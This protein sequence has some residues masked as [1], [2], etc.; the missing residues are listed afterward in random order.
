L[1]ESNEL[2]LLEEGTNPENVPVSRSATPSS[3]VKDA[4][5]STGTNNSGE[6][7]TREQRIAAAL[8]RTAEYVVENIHA[9]DQRLSLS[10]TTLS[11]IA[12]VQEMDERNQFSATVANNV[13]SFDEKYQVSERAQHA[14]NTTVTRAQ[15]LDATCKITENINN[16][17]TQMVGCV[18]DFDRRYD[19]TTRIT[20]AIF[21]GMATISE[22]VTTYVNRLT[23]GSAVASPEEVANS[24]ALTD[25]PLQQTADATTISSE[26][27]GDNV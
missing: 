3:G 1:E 9:I 24:V 14:V 19:V 13:K 10:T 11:A 20:T 2:S 5:K 18:G 12:K 8:V 17:G 27:G 4:T 15:E 22:A 25:A 21:V 7:E 16:A 6:P 26:S 23:S